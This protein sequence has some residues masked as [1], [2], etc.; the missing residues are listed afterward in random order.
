[1]NALTKRGDNHLLFWIGATLLLVFF[2]LGDTAIVAWSASLVSAA[3][4]AV[5]GVAFLSISGGVLFTIWQMR[6]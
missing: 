6:G 4:L 3:Q 1:M 5:A 2:G